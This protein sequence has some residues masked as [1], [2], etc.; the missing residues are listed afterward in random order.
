MQ[1]LFFLSFLLV[2]MA[3]IALPGMTP[4][5]WTI[6]ER[7]ISRRF[8][9]TS[10]ISLYELG[11]KRVVRLPSACLTQLDEN[12]YVVELA[13][14]CGE[15]VSVSYEYRWGPHPKRTTF[16]IIC[17]PRS[18]IMQLHNSRL[19]RNGTVHDANLF[20][21]SFNLQYSVENLYHSIN[22]FV[23]PAVGLFNTIAAEILREGSAA[24]T[25]YFFQRE[26]AF[27]ANNSMPWML[28]NTMT[29]PHERYFQMRESCFYS[30]L[31]EI[32]ETSLNTLS[33]HFDFKS[34]PILPQHYFSHFKHTHGF[35]EE[36]VGYS[37]YEFPP[38][39]GLIKRLNSRSILNH[40]SIIAS[41]L[42][43]G[44]EVYPLVF[45]GLSITAQAMIVQNLTTLVGYHGAGLAWGTAMHKDA[46]VIEIQ[47]WPCPKTTHSP[48]GSGDRF[49]ILPTLIDSLRA[50]SAFNLSSKWCAS[51]SIAEAANR[52]NIT[53]DVR[54]LDAV[55]NI[56]LLEE[57]LRVIDPVLRPPMLVKSINSA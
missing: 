39:I 4:T 34:S 50:D 3:T 6:L 30:V 38:R 24:L 32:N 53:D 40:D 43:Q 18:S 9:S 28:W 16:K 46:A 13:Y 49:R 20:L 23:G 44:Y 11:N 2:V 25:A 52:T 55:V 14:A 19:E 7:P 1:T 33:K 54:L 22:Q 42:A 21:I 56:S 15:N 26:T 27:L 12:S 10:T 29:V 5:V 41:L 31:L 57:T 48:M 47:G 51:E 37:Y 45:D 36:Q 35:S 17:R 8:A